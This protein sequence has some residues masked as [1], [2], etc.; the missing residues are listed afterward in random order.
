MMTNDEI[1]RLLRQAVRLPPVGQARA[2]ERLTAAELEEADTIMSG[3]RAEAGHAEIPI[4]GRDDVCGYCGV[5]V[6]SNGA[7]NY[8]YHPAAFLNR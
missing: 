6:R 1:D 2:L 4:A 7:I 5:L 3:R 8:A